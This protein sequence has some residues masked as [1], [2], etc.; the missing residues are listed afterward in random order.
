MFCV[1]RVQHRGGSAARRVHLM[2]SRIQTF[3]VAEIFSDLTRNF[4]FESS[5]SLGKG[6]CRRKA[7]HSCTGRLPFLIMSSR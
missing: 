2:V 4:K 5:L 1:Q 7:I 6:E 3:S